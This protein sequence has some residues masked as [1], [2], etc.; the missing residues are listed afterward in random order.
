MTYRTPA[1]VGNEFRAHPRRALIITIVVHESRAVKAH[2]TEPEAVIGGNGTL[3]YEYGRFSDPAGEWLVV[4]ALT[5]QGN[6]DAALVA[7]K[8]YQEF[9]SFHAQIVVGVAGSLKE[10]I[11][12]GSIVIGDYVYNGHSAKVED[13]ETLGRPHGLTAARE[14][15]TA[16]QA[17][18]YSDEWRNLITSPVGMDLP[19]TANYPCPFPPL[20]VIKGIVSGEEVVAGGLSTRYKWLRSHFNDCAAVEM[21]GWGTMKAAHYENASAIVVRGI[22]DMCAG[23]SHETDKLHQPIAAAHAAAF[24]FGILS[25]RSKVPFQ[26]VPTVENNTK[27]PAITPSETADIPAQEARRID[28]VFNF[29]GSKEEWPNEKVNSVVQH[30]KHVFDDQKLTLVRIDVGSVRLVVSVRETDIPK[31]DLTK[32][33]QAAE[34]S[35]AILLGATPLEKVLDAEKARDALRA[36]SADLL[37]WEKTLPGG[38]WME[39]PEREVIESRFELG[40]STTVLLGDPGSGKSALL[41]RI[42]CD[43]LEQGATVFALKSDFLPTEVQTES[44]LQTALHLPISASELVLRVAALQPV[45][46]LID[47]LDALA[48]Q[49]DLRT[50][51]LNVLLN[52]VRRVGETPNVHILLSART[53][54]FNH[55]VRLRAIEAEAVTL[56]LPPWHEIKEQLAGIGINADAWPEKARDVVRIPQALKTFISLAHAGRTEPFTTYQAMLE[57]MWQDK[58][59]SADDCDNLVALASDLAGLMAEEE[60]LWLA[61]SRFDNRLKT[62]KRLEALGLIVRSENSLSIAFNHQ[63]V[64]DYVLARTF[65]RDVGLLS[66][67]VLERQ[68]SLFVRGKAWSALNYLREAE[69]KSYEREFLEIWTAKELRRHLR[70]LLI[71]FLG[72]INHPLKFEKICMADVLNSPELRLFGLRAIA[73]SRSGWFGEF[74]S[75]VIRDAMLGT[76]AEASQALRIL[77]ANWETSTVQ[78]VQLIRECWLPHAAKDNY[79]WMAVY[80]CRNWTSEVEE[81]ARIVLGRTPI[82]IW[83][84]D[85]AARTVAVEQPEVAIRLVR[86]KLDSLFV[87]A[88]DRPEPSKAPITGTAETASLHVGHHQTREMEKLLDAIE[89]TD[90]PSLAENAPATFLQYL[91]P[92]YI[93]V[94]TQILTYTRNKEAGYIYPG[95]YALELELAQPGSEFA[96]RETPVK[97]ALQIAVKELAADSPEQ[98]SKWAN[99]NSPVEILS[100]QQLIALGYV[101]A[102]D[103]LALQA[104]EWLLSDSRRFQLG[105]RHGLRHTTVDLVRMCAPH[106]TQANINLFEKA[107]LDYHPE[108]PKHLTEPEQRRL[109]A[110]VVRATKKDLLQALGTERLTS[111][112]QELVATEQRALGNR[113]DRSVGPIEGGWIGSPMDAA[114]MA[115]AKDRDILRIF[116]EI[117]DDSDWNHPTHWMKGGNIQLSRAFAEFARTNPER[118]IRII[119]QFEPRKQ[120]RAAGYALDAMADDTSNKNQIINAFLDLNTRGFKTEEFRDSAARS[121]EKISSKAIDIGDDV[122]DILVSWLHISQPSGRQELDDS[123]IEL[124]LRSEDE[125]SKNASI[126]WGLGDV[127]ALPGG[128]FNTLSAL[129]TILL[130]RREPGRDR[131]ISILNDHLLVERDPNVWKSLLYRLGNAG[132]ST[133]QVV[134]AFIRRLFDR[135]P[136]IL[137]TRD[138]IIFLAYA[139]RW[140]D[141]LVFEFIGNW[142]GSNRPFLQRAY[143]EL[144]GLVAM[145]KDKDVWARAKSEIIGSNNE[146]MKIGLAYAG[147]NIW[148]DKSLRPKATRTLV[149]LLRGANKEL[150]A[151]VMD[152]FRVADELLPGPSTVELL[153]ALA[154]PDADLSGAPS[155]FVVERLQTL[156]PHEAELVASIAGKLV[157]A[158]RDKLGN[159]QTEVATVAPQLT[160]LAITLHRLGGNSRRPGIELFEAMIEI[161]A[162]GAR[163]TLSEID[164][165][166]GPQQAPPR[167]RLSRRRNPRAQSASSTGEN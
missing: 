90:L 123:D 48:S 147:V 118:G 149:A 26:G 51:R 55:D 45:Y 117:P 97:L 127:S 105:T 101:V 86:A 61:A 150:V 116:R 140:D 9:G 161:D 7:S 122:I 120:E 89:W 158:W 37:A 102:A 52:F 160:D 95:H 91:W 111:E 84:V 75:T 93:S 41:S 164:G 121:I 49:L 16:A 58:I 43:L 106:W 59:A 138:A 112:N 159:L 81:I 56:K 152:I 64:F 80:E 39:R 132:G 114:A 126:L 15:L 151:A 21:E 125:E 144:V 130:N 163:E 113:F 24:A 131:Y 27:P 73:N 115:K 88:K 22:S 154:S 143:G 63:T 3:Y 99:E 17:L 30:L 65:V 165:R 67:Y 133:P 33:R 20:A 50:G 32:L 2:L 68:D 166:F 142:V 153:R 85:H 107:I 146:E 156:L 35:G 72:Q 10:D 13:T 36:A 44:D 109:F 53:F 60:A 108:A 5:H 29:H 31:I 128:N 6:S 141:Q 136:E 4:H 34:V 92:W 167:Q 78:I 139:Q 98:F 77:S 38:K 129:A 70:L 155:H 47:Q 8:A 23:K 74:S 14:L 103:Q 40:T 94:F 83:Q 1:D 57:Q 46:I 28:F 11:P 87:E 157:A 71:E 19:N 110:D 12:I 100:V 137:E 25:F 148:S 145:S 66:T 62:L 54:E 162:Y 104:L 134:S 69:A 135:F 119:E 96:R 82:S 18:I 76:D 42:A 79:S 124:S